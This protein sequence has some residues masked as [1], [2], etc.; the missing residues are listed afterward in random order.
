MADKPTVLLVEDDAAISDMYA[1]ALGA[2]GF[3]VVRAYTAA[4]ALAR[5]S[6]DAPDVVLLDI[7]LP[8]RPGT[9]VLEEL[10]KSGETAGIPVLMLSNYDEPD[11]VD[12]ALMAGALL[13]LVKA[14]TTP[15]AVASTVRTVLTGGS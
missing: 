15:R 5:A 2:G 12:R 13:Y 10:K 3:E 9:E 6:G 7:G 1:L 11:I 14:E 8:D 4:E